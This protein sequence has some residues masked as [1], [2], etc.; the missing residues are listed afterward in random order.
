MSFWEL[1]PPTGLRE[2][3]TNHWKNQEATG[4]GKSAGREGGSVC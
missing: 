2:R 3:P 4:P 1:L